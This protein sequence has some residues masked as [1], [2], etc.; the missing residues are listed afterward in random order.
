M[1]CPHCTVR[2][3]D[4]WF[5]QDFV[6]PN[7]KVARVGPDGAT[8]FWRCRSAQCPECQDVTIEMCTEARADRRGIIVPLLAAITANTKSARTG[9]Q[10]GRTGRIEGSGLTN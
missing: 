2:F 5:V 8:E 10:Q 9:L 7:G 3:H 1:K 6:R 4:N